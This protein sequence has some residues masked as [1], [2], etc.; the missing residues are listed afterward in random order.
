[1]YSAR[2]HHKIISPAYEREVA[3]GWILAPV[4]KRQN[5]TQLTKNIPSGPR[6]QRVQDEVGSFR[7]P[8]FQQ[9]EDVVAKGRIGFE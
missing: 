6:R 2:Q 9:N 7:Y 3:N 8:Y 4:A 5:E 1:M